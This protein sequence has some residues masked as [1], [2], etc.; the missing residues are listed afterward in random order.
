MEHINT[1]EIP[2]DLSHGI[3]ANENLSERDLDN[4]DITI[5]DLRTKIHGLSGFLEDFSESWD[6]S[7]NNI[8]RLREKHNI[9][10]LSIETGIFDN[11]N[12]KLFAD[13]QL[14]LGHDWAQLAEFPRAIRV[15]R[16]WN[17]EEIYEY[18]VL[19]NTAILAC[20]EN[21]LSIITG[22]ETTE[23]MYRPE[24]ML[25]WYKGVLG[26]RFWLEDWNKSEKRVED[27]K[28]RGL[29][30]KNNI[31]VYDP[32]RIHIHT[33]PW[34]QLPWS[35]G[36]SLMMAMY[37]WGKNTIT[38]GEMRGKLYS[39]YIKDPL[40]NAYAELLEKRIKKN[41][42]II[43]VHMEVFETP[44]AYIW[45]VS[46][47]GAGFDLNALKSALYELTMDEERMADMLRLGIISEEMIQNIH[48]WKTDPRAYGK[49]LSDLPSLLKMPRFSSANS[50][51]L[52]I[53]WM[54]HSWIGL[55]GIEVS[56]RQHFATTFITE[57]HD[58]GAC[59]IQVIPKDPEKYKKILSTESADSTRTK[60]GDIL[61]KTPPHLLAA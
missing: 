14:F 17:E 35:T 28:K 24:V 37:N 49:I 8:S 55:Y 13:I 1:P 40:A 5:Q 32:F 3:F 61:F 41:N 36:A 44:E 26:R 56:A 31:P 51:K 47:T 30:D 33:T 10:S 45:C 23:T 25:E 59:M 38:T 12:S 20:F 29:L 58:G 2:V 21:T 22:E 52:A 54:D 46:D 27:L 60:V 15:N 57:L 16:D 50:K 39:D 19:S 43:D 4:I 11:T 34:L 9:S 42:G 6:T 18:Y 48:E 53:V 7:N